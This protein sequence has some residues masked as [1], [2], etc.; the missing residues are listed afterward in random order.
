MES[1]ALLQHDY[2]FLAAAL[3]A[4][5]FLAAALLAGAFL[6]AALLAGAFLATALLAGAFL[7]FG[8]AF[9]FTI[10]PPESELTILTHL[11]DIEV[12]NKRPL[13]LVPGLIVCQVKFIPE[14]QTPSI[15]CGCFQPKRPQFVRH[16][17]YLTRL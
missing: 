3:L 7:A 11:L 6:A 15:S 2:F 1:Y 8:F 9:A 14:S 10:S 4:G 12:P 13:Y 16:S 5:A 17:G